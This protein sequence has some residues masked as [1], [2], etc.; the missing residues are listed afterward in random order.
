[1]AQRS[2]SNDRYRKD[3][4]IGHTR[5]SAAK[6]KPIRKQGTVEASSSPAKPKKAGQEKDWTGL[7]TSPEI[8]KWRRIWWSLLLGGLALIG[9]GY[10]VPE[11]R[12]NATVQAVIAGVVLG[13]SLLAVTIDLVVIRKLRKQLIAAQAPKKHA[14]K[15]TGAG[16]KTSSTAD[17]S[18]GAAD[19]KRGW[20][21]WRKDR[22]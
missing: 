15:G 13:A 19:A 17:A 22:T 9:I 8:K 12:E 3:A 20:G 11:L 14:Q 18:A 16:E 6:A 21:P 7:P 4:K 10:L 1:V 2:F 5:K